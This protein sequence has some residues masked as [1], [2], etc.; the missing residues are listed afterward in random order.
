MLLLILIS[1]YRRGD[2]VE[3]DGIGKR[4]GVDGYKEGVSVNDG[5]LVNWDSSSRRSRHVLAHG[6]IADEFVD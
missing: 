5:G 4:R 6:A 3:R 1:S 2:N